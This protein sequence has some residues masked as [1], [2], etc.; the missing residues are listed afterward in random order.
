M[1]RVGRGSRLVVSIVFVLDLVRLSVRPHE[2]ALA[3]SGVSRV[4]S[5]IPDIPEGCIV[6]R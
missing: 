6:G 1:R 3:S 2:Q 4:R 5:T